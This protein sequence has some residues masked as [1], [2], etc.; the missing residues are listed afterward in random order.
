MSSEPALQKIFTRILYIEEVKDIHKDENLRI[1][2][3]SSE[4]N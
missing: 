3:I 1:K 2:E 4:K